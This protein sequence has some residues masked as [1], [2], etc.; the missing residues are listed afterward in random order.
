VRNVRIKRARI[1]ASGKISGESLL[2]KLVWAKVKK[3]D[4]QKQQLFSIW[5]ETKEL[6]YLPEGIPYKVS[7]TPCVKECGATFVYGLNK[8]F[9][10]VSSYLTPAERINAARHELR[11]WERLTHSDESA[12]QM[13]G[14]ATEAHRV[15][16]SGEN[17][18]LRKS[19]HGKA[20]KFIRENPDALI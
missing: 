2:T 4:W 6:E 7:N 17:P 8:P 1:V 19:T 5:R 14:V 9:L 20:E 10:L 13:F 12:A 16:A 15:A 18:R 11:E 3:L